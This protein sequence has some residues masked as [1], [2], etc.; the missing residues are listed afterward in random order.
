MLPSGLSVCVCVWVCW[1]ALLK[2]KF[3]SLSL[4]SIYSDVWMIHTYQTGSESSLSWW[5]W[6]SC[7]GDS[8]VLGGKSG[9]KVQSGKSTFFFTSRRV[10]LWLITERF[11]TSFSLEY[12]KH[13]FCLWSLMLQCE[14]RV[15]SVLDGD[16]IMAVNVSIANL[17]SSLVI[18]T[19]T[20]CSTVIMKTFW[21]SLVLLSH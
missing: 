6:H 2:F 11:L 20:L 1:Q 17:L 12:Q 14:S 3:W 8:V 18:F 9:V 4:M 5:L 16:C 21:Y 13:K 7:S 15:L 19:P 10:W